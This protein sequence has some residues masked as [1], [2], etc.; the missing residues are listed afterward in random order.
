MEVEFNGRTTG[1]RKL[2]VGGICVSYKIAYEG[3]GNEDDRYACF[4]NLI[5]LRTPAPLMNAGNYHVQ[6]SPVEHGDS[7][8][9]ICSN[10]RNGYN[11][12][13]M[14]ISGDVD[15]GYFLAAEDIQNYLRKNNF[16]LNCSRVNEESKISV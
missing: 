11:W 6:K 16:D 8:S 2:V 5:E 13:G 10:D 4:T 12:C 7:G 15:R 9:W 3:E 1:F 14:L